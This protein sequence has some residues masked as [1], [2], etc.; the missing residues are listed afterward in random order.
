MWWIVP[1]IVLV[2]VVLMILCVT[3][4]KVLHMTTLPYDTVEIYDIKT[5]IDILMQQDTVLKYSKTLSHVVKYKYI[6]KLAEERHSVAQ[7]TNDTI[8]IASTAKKIIVDNMTILNV[9]K[10]CLCKRIKLCGVLPHV[11]RYPRIY[12]I[13]QLLC[14]AR[15]NMS[16]IVEATQLSTRLTMQEYAQLDIV[17]LAVLLHK[18]DS[19]ANILV[20]NMTVRQLGWRDSIN[21]YVDIILMLDSNYALGYG[22]QTDIETRHK[23]NRLLLQQD[24]N[25]DKLIQQSI[26]DDNNLS[27]DAIYILNQLAN[28]LSQFGVRHCLDMHGQSVA[29]HYKT[30][31]YSQYPSVNLIYSDRY[32]SVIDTTGCGYSYIDGL[33]ILDGARYIG[34]FG[35]YA[36]IE[37]NVYSV[38]DRAIH[39]HNKSMYTIQYGG[40]KV[41]TTATVLQEYMSDVRLMSISNTTSKAIDLDIVLDCKVATTIK[42]GKTIQLWSNGRQV[43]SISM[44]GTR[45]E[46]LDDKIVAR[47][48]LNPHCSTE[49]ATC[50]DC[51]DSHKL[52]IDAIRQS[53]LVNNARYIV[54]QRVLDLLSRLIYKSVMPYPQDIAQLG[55]DISNHT[56]VVQ[57]HGVDYTSLLDN[58]A[59][60]GRLYPIVKY[61]L[62]VLYT[63]NPSVTDYIKPN[64]LRLLDTCSISHNSSINIK[65]LNTLKISSIELD[66]LYKHAECLDAIY[67]NLA[68]HVVLPSI[69]SQLSWDVLLRVR[70]IYN[71]NHCRSTMVRPKIEAECVSFVPM[72][73]DCNERWYNNISNGLIKLDQYGKMYNGIQGNII[74]KIGD[75]IV[76]PCYSMYMT[77]STVQYDS[78]HY[79]DKS[80]YT[81]SYRDIHCTLE[82]F[83]VKS[84]IYKLS[85]R[86]NTDNIQSIEV[87]FWTDVP[88]YMQ[89]CQVL[90]RSNSISVAGNNNQLVVT[91]S[92]PMKGFCA[93]K[94][95]FCNQ[96]G[97]IDKIS[98][99]AECSGVTPCIAFD[100]LINCRPN[101][102][103]DMQVGI[104]H[105]CHDYLSSRR[106]HIS[107]NNIQGNQLLADVV[108]WLPRYCV[109]EQGLYAVFGT[110]YQDLSC[111]RQLLIDN[112]QHKL[113]Y[114]LALCKYCQVVGNNDIL[115]QYVKGRSDRLTKL[116][117]YCIDIL[118]S[119]Y[120]V[121]N[122]GLVIGQDDKVSLYGNIML[123][124][125]I[126]QLTTVVQYQ[127][128]QYWESIADNIQELLNRYY[129]QGS[130]YGVG[131]KIDIVVQSLAI[132]SGVAQ[133][134]STSLARMLSQAVNISKI[135][136]KS[137]GAVYLIQTFLMLQ[138]PDMAYTI[139]QKMDLLDNKD[140]GLF[141]LQSCN[142]QPILYSV[143]LENL[144]GLKISGNKI[145]FDPQLPS[146]V[147]KVVL[148]LGVDRCNIDVQ[149]YNRQSPN[150]WCMS[151]EQVRHS[152]TSILI[153]P[154]LHNKTITLRR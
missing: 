107:I 143:L 89:G 153:Q 150:N 28:I 154:N 13:C 49:I 73:M 23:Y 117:D 118:R 41:E 2:C 95:S 127:S 26:I 17:Y 30:V 106:S 65:V 142:W 18:I 136:Y 121:D 34:G 96:Y 137:I 15:V 76:S 110:V 141:G 38:Y 86:N 12:K 108:R 92:R 83:V 87:F 138:Q 80:V 58:I 145:H 90:R 5:Q 135:N 66:Q 27:R 22:Q 33:R 39:T 94:E 85:I 88:S 69:T 133:D 16:T 116:F 7:D 75:R 78:K 84:I 50:I 29:M 74:L 60:L 112:V 62:I 140:G 130:H 71:T 111:A 11:G 6:G 21:K 139:L 54:S 42:L 61:N 37:G 9:A 53:C 113:N 3:L 132:L 128:L 44:L 98:N 123:I 4:H 45:Y 93:S 48:G 43:A 77:H 79:L 124:W 82:V 63:H 40:I 122:R 99:L 35:L 67:D 104:K 59:Q 119:V 101:S 134:R 56:I 114:I 151:I 146:F 97:A 100:S 47:I 55:I 102:T 115:H 105:S 1:T 70:S 24:T 91:S 72:L 31:Q 144:L 152:I 131:K 51:N 126:R 14:D 129:W 32:V 120:I 149:I 19:I 25:I 125:C 10:H 147:D 109:S 52:N 57:L 103:V 46:I 20:C 8:T 64:I 68:T 81:C 36:V 148:Q